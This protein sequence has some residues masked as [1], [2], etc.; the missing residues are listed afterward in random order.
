[1]KWLDDVLDHI[2]M[3][4]L[5][6]YY[7]IGLEVVAV[8]L[9][10]SGVLHYDPIDV[11]FCALYLNAVCWLLNKIFGAFFK[12][13]TNVESPYITAL[14]LA[15]IISP[16]S[17]THILLFMTI[18]A[19]LAISSKFILAIHDRHIFNPA[20]IA[21][22]LTAYGA[23]NAASWW[24]GTASMLPFVIIGGVLLVRRIRRTEMVL[25]FVGSVLVATAIY[26]FINGSDVDILIQ[27][28]IL[29]SALF[30]AGFVM[31][32]EPL[33]SPTTHGKRAWYSIIVG[34]LFP[35]QFNIFG[36]YASPE[37]A[38]A[39]GNI[40]SFVVGPR[41]K[42]FLKLK[43]KIKVSRDS[44]DFVFTP[45]RPF[46][47]QPGQYMEFTFQHPHTDSH[48]ARRYFTLASSPTE[49]DIRV[50]IKFYDPGSSYKQHLLEATAE[51]PIIAGQLGGD[52]VLPKDTSRKLVFIAGGIGVT[53]FRS[54]VKYLLDT[55]QLR[56]I[57]LLYAAKTAD[58]HL[59]RDIFD[60]A[61]QRL[62]A[63]VVYITSAG[64]AKPP[65][66]QRLI[67]E[68]VPQFRDCLFYIS[69]PHGMVVGTE[70]VLVQ[71]GVPRRHI[72]KDFFSGY[73]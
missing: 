21:V 59:Y 6:L 23:G 22:I 72:K 67:Q 43:D 14:I 42:T 11:V 32:T 53:P 29:N 39:V 44:M 27:K 12:A 48:G 13:P 24:V 35:P 60:A 41:A 31:L 34:A 63:H 57:T 62:N 61:V 5:L 37:I 71:M 16:G 66:Y 33:T 38:L 52:F 50:G 20:A 46:T 54:M 64:K 58:D 8:G 73:A 47:Y 15:L 51:T 19:L 45:A 17:G 1:M 3:Y 56:D 26:G 69:G 25:W 68:H 36:L 9:A 7:L 70:E 28:E 10:A 55:K 4:R 30:F 65:V 18:A 2:T 40:Y 49:R